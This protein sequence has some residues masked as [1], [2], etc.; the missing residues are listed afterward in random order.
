MLNQIIAAAPRAPDSLS[1]DH[2]PLLEFHRWKANLRI[3]EIAEI[4]TVPYVA[5]ASIH[6]ALDRHGPS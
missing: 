6:R 3:R 1:S 4:K 2:D 5:I